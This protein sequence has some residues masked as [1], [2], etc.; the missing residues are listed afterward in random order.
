M[1]VN[2]LPYISNPIEEFKDFK[3]VS[4][5]RDIYPQ[6]KG[7]MKQDEI[8]FYA[9]IIEQRNL[10]SF[11]DFGVGG[12]LE[13]SGIL[14]TLERR[15]YAWTRAEANEVDDGFIKQ[16]GALFYKKQQHVLIHH[17]N[18]LDLPKA[19]PPYEGTFDFALLTGNSLTYI[20]GGTREYKK[21]AQ[22]IIVNKFAQLI[23][24][25]GYFF[26]DSRNYDYIHS[27]MNLPTD[28]IFQHFIFNDSVYYHGRVLV[29]PA[30]ISD[31]VV[32]FHYY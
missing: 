20:G 15:K 31:T 9:D 28:Q 24:P 25:G 23:E 13:L 17:A 12:G 21:K 10:H 6:F 8:D 22:Q 18:W 3:L 19:D 27:L 7:K 4:W 29:F 26:I 32:V 16:S 5:E 14:E 1:F 11:L 30:Y 2:T